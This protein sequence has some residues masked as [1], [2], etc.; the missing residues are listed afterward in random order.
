MSEVTPKAVAAVVEMMTLD[1]ARE[2]YAAAEV[3]LTLVPNHCPSSDEVETDMEKAGK[4]QRLVRIPVGLCA[5]Q[6]PRRENIL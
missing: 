2:Q 1:G 3:R 4:P 5:N 6:C